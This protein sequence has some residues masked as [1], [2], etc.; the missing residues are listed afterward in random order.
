MKLYLMKDEWYP[1]AVPVL[2][3]APGSFISD[4]LVDVD[5]A[6]VKKYEDARD[7]FGVAERE[8]IRAYIKAGGDSYGW[9][10]DENGEEL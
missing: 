7:A 4:P 10:F 1:V 9:P 2:E 3:G 8:L 5:D 6:I